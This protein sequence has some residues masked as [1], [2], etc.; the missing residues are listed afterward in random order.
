MAQP[1]VTELEISLVSCEACDMCFLFSPRRETCPTC[2]GGPGLTLFEWTGYSNGLH[3]KTELPADYA[4]TLP[5]APA[6]VEAPASDMGLPANVRGDEAPGA[7]AVS[8]VGAELVAPPPAGGTAQIYA[9]RVSE[10]ADLAAVAIIRDP[11]DPVPLRAAIAALGAEPE[12]MS[13][14][15]GRLEAVRA[16][17]HEVATHGLGESGPAVNG[18]DDEEE[19]EEGEEEERG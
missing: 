5:P 15:I 16:Y 13:M 1:E 10:L 14:V 3:L 8:P 17:I 19:E 11:F 7:S 2:G 9:R 6:P 18:D 12:E 4:A